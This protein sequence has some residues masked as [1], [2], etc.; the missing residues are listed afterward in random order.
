MAFM[1]DMYIEVHQGTCFGE[2][3]TYTLGK[4][5]QRWPMARDIILDAWIDSN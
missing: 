2:A 3:Y 1:I 5:Y 4:H